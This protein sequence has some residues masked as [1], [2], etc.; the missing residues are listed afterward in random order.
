[1]PK[2]Y[3]LIIILSIQYVNLYAQQHKMLP[4]KINGTINADTGTIELR[5][6]V[7]PSFYPENLRKLSRHVKN[8]KFYFSG[9]LP[10][11]QGFELLYNSERSSSDFIIEA[12]TQSIT[13]NIDSSS[14]T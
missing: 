14:A 4:F 11:P 13:Y 3:S 10:S 9:Y 1:M 6:F 8:K 2:S 7:D 12:G 5:M